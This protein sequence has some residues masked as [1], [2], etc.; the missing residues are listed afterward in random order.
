MY[1]PTK[2]SSLTSVGGFPLCTNV[3]YYNQPDLAFCSGSLISNKASLSDNDALVILTAGHCV[4]TQTECEGIYFV[5]GYQNPSSSAPYTDG[6]FAKKDVYIC[7][8]VL[9]IQNNNGIDYAVLAIKPVDPT[10]QGSSSS[11]RTPMRYLANKSPNAGEALAFASFPLGVPLKVSRGGQVK[12]LNSTDKYWILANLDSFEGSS[13]GMIVRDSDNLIIASMTRGN[14]DLVQSD[15]LSNCWE[16]KVC[17]DD[18]GCEGSF[19][20]AY[21]SIAWEQ[22]LPDYEGLRTTPL[23]SYHVYIMY[24]GV[25]SSD[26]SLTS[27][28]DGNGGTV[29]Y[30]PS[31]FFVD[32]QNTF[33]TSG[34]NV[35]V[36]FDR[37]LGE[38]ITPLSILKNDPGQAE[39]SEQNTPVSRDVFTIGPQ[40]KQRIWFA[41]RL[42]FW[43]GSSEKVREQF[44]YITVK[45]TDVERSRSRYLQFGYAPSTRLCSI[46]KTFTSYFSNHTH[47]SDTFPC[48]G[49]SQ[50]LY[51][52]T[53]TYVLVPKVD[54]K[55]SA[56]TCGLTLQST[57]LSISE[58][59][60]DYSISELSCAGSGTCSTTQSLISNYAVKANH[61]YVIHA[62][63]LDY[64]LVA[65]SSG[66]SLL[67]INGPS[68]PATE[69]EVS[70]AVY[71]SSP[72]A[73][74]ELVCSST[75]A[76]GPDSSPVSTSATTVPSDTPTLA[77][78]PLASLNTEQ[79]K[80]AV[81]F[82]L[83]KTTERKFAEIIEE[84]NKLLSSQLNVQLS[85][86]RRRRSNE[87]AANPVENRKD[88]VRQSDNLSENILE[89]RYRRG[90]MVSN[91]DI[92]VGSL[93][94]NVAGDLIVTIVAEA[95]DTESGE[96]FVVSAEDQVVRALSSIKDQVAN[97]LGIALEG[98]EATPKIPSSCSG[99]GTV[100]KHH[101]FFIATLSL[102]FL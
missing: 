32:L 16:Y 58:L 3:K 46:N 14:A 70:L 95:V 52:S 30:N 25:F 72:T 50:A 41:P 101:M 64:K 54:G 102:Y 71:I 94:T 15:T 84:F 97:S 7:D 86:A 73:G 93:L 76:S 24:H 74:M 22:S 100:K 12:Y 36:T 89:G 61:T 57:I 79:G 48:K 62:S 33:S 21:T 10:V 60:S 88:V 18:N 59:K 47:R 98:V 80:Q 29:A 82:I 19:E 43:K 42:T 35:E 11:N 44:P 92:L 28:A 8:V 4:S 66:A 85:P 90:A 49:S 63:Y 68:V 6:K 20:L 83:L 40:E 31:L 39:Q 37:P 99:L 5:F 91:T 13:G 9:D 75:D 77:S 81:T 55:I 67:D 38:S 34:I 27:S 65:V 23:G 87:P 53:I 96:R 45:A 2:S 1:E 51:Q 69:S 56:S 26:S 17:G 78:V